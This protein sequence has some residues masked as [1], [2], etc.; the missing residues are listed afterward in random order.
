[1]CSLWFPGTV[2]AAMRPDNALAHARPFELQECNFNIANR[3][4]QQSTKSSIYSIIHWSQILYFCNKARVLRTVKITTHKIHK[5]CVLW[6]LLKVSFRLMRIDYHCNRM[7]NRKT[8]AGSAGYLSSF[9]TSTV[10]YCV[11]FCNFAQANNRN[12]L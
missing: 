6:G 2:R 9:V 5:W 8:L 7:I 10:H 1:M 12:I 11:Q 4:L 3:T